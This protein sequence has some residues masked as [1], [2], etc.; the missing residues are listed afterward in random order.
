MAEPPMAEYSKR[1]ATRYPERVKA[2]AAATRALLYGRMA[3]PPDLCPKCGNAPPQF[4]D[5]RRTMQMHHYLG[6][7][8][9]LDIE[10]LCA[11]CHHADRKGQKM[12]S[13]YPRRIV[14][15]THCCHGHELAGDN[16]RMR[17]GIHGGAGKARRCCLACEREWAKQA[18]RRAR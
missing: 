11:K 12:P 18:R 16:L 13:I 14:L 5:G 3:P 4:K 9:P 2:R 8:H 1:H 6:Y 15:K 17:G 10:W 7:D